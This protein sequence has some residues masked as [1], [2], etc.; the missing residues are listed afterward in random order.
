MNNTDN[1][2]PRNTPASGTGAGKISEKQ[3]GEKPIEKPV[4]NPIEKPVEKPAENSAEKLAEKF[5]EK[6]AEKAG[7]TAGN[8]ASEQKDRPLTEEAAAAGPQDGSSYTEQLSVEENNSGGETSAPPQQTED[9]ENANRDV[10]LP[11]DHSAV[12][13]EQLNAEKKNRILKITLSTLLVAIGAFLLIYFVPRAIHLWRSI[14]DFEVYEEE[15]VTYAEPAEL[16]TEEDEEEEIILS[17]NELRSA[18]DLSTALR[19]WAE[20]SDDY[21][22]MKSKKVINFLLI[23]CDEN[24]KLADV[25]MIVSLNLNTKQI[26]LTSVMRDSY[27]YI[28]IKNSDTYGKINSAYQYGGATLVKST[29]ER[30]F[31]IDI[32]YYV[33]VN[34]DMLVGI[35]NTMGGITLDVEAYEAQA[36]VSDELFVDLAHLWDQEIECP[37]GEQVTLNGLQA[38]TYCRIRHCDIDADISRTRRQRQL[39][40]ALIEKSRSVS[41]DQIDAILDQFSVYLRT[42]CPKN[43]LVELATRAIT[44]KWYNYEIISNSFPQEGERLDYSGYAWVW[45]VDYPLSAYNL[46]NLIYGESNIILSEDRISVIDIMQYTGN[47]GTAAP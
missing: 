20:N 1:R 11:E 10:V 29:I 43:E 31:K 40:E 8:N 34:Y 9:T 32:D 14:R 41:L 4:E 5:A 7:M 2:D 16:V 38:L 19:E 25:I 35:V 36:I 45:I 3:P 22:L 26:F 30:D 23:G 27:T 24:Q 18:N 28:P 12:P 39:I 44:G 37:Y 21:V 42:N 15:S 33:S 6:L 13:P 47:V 17:L 46:H